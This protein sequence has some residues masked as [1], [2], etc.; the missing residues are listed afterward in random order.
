MK[1]FFSVLFFSTIT[2][3]ADEPSMIFSQKIFELQKNSEHLL[4]KVDIAHTKSSKN[5]ITQV[6]TDSQNKIPKEFAYSDFF[7]KSVNF[8]FHVYTQYDQSEVLIHDKGNPGLV[9][10]TLNFDFLHKIYPDDFDRVKVQNHLAGVKLL[11]IK[12][13][14][15]KIA[16]GKNIT[17]KSLKKTLIDYFGKIPKKKTL[18]TLSEELRTQ[19]G[20]RDH[21][22]LA[23]NNLEGYQLIFNKLTKDFSLP[24]EIVALSILE[25]RFNPDAVSIVDAKGIWQIMPYIG[26][27]LFP[28]DKN[29]QYEKSIPISTLGAFEILRQ[30]YRFFKNW[31][32]ALTAYN[33][34]IQ[35]VRKQLKN[36]PK[37]QQSLEGLIKFNKSDSL[38]FAAFNFYTEFLALVHTVEYSNLIFSKHKFDHH[39][40]LYF[41]FTNCSLK[42]KSFFKAFDKPELVE[43][44]NQHLELE[45][46]Y[47][48]GII[49]AS[50]VPLTKKRYT[51]IPPDIYRFTR[52]SDF[53]KK[54]K[55]KPCRN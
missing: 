45:L 35:R 14:L 51:L 24:S 44:L 13:D 2:L 50:H 27:I 49:I 54:I 36:V 34:G 19:T 43:D 41:Y 4:T 16:A 15:E 9:Y 42:P 12:N 46:E 8:W 53:K 47:P 31:G 22:Q 10:T 48:R 52:V 6:L 23:V 3:H 17:N 29:I 28:K 55:L 18:L 33:S 1:I 21:I 20:L 37:N 25:S 38:G 26:A 32:L 39:S 30:N 11:Q 7:K 5:I 40:N